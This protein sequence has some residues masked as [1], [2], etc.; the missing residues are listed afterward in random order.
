MAI[1]PDRFSDLANGLQE[2]LLL[3][4]ERATAARVAAS[5]GDRLYNAIARAVEAA[6]Q[7]RA[8]AYDNAR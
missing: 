7:L 1:D 8:G 6:R 4:G 5:D 2:A 3:A